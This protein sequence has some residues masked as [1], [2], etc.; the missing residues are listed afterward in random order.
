MNFVVENLTCSEMG[1]GVLKDATG[2]PSVDSIFVRESV[3]LVFPD[4]GIP[5]TIITLDLSTG[6]YLSFSIMI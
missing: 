1:P 5:E 6:P 2:I 3:N 4:P